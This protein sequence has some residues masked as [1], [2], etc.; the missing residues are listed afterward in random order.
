MDV[1][2]RAAGDDTWIFA[3]ADV[4]F[5]GEATNPS[6]SRAEAVRSLLPYAE[7]LLESGDKLHRISRHMNGLM[8]GLPH[9]KRWRRLLS[10]E[11]QQPGASPEVLVQALQHIVN[12]EEQAAAYLAQSHS[13]QS[14]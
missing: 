3:D 13:A 11:A 7:S 14:Q 1:S 2:G 6:A 12:A 9:G 8:R 5:Y 4:R 10:E